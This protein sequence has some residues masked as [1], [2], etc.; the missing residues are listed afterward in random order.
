VTRLPLATQAPEHTLGGREGQADVVGQHAD[1]VAEGG[2]LGLNGGGV[3]QLLVEGADIIDGRDVVGVVCFDGGDE[4]KVGGRQEK[5][6]Q[7]SL[8][9]AKKAA[10]M[11]SVTG[12]ASHDRELPMGDL[13]RCNVEL[14]IL[15]VGSKALVSKSRWINLRLPEDEARLL[16]LVRKRLVNGSH[17]LPDLV[18]HVFDGHGSVRCLFAFDYGH[19]TIVED[20]SVFEGEVVEM[21]YA[22]G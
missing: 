4:G 13:R 1:H 5:I 17:L 11:T 9:G 16:E 7:E 3:A 21:V 22:L 20:R 10:G 15:E 6:V 14:A 12:L 19:E 18:H 8:E 2:A